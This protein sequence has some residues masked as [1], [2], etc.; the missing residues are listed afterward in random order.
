VVPGNPAWRMTLPQWR[1]DVAAMLRAPDAPGVLRCSMLAD[2]RGVDDGWDL[3]VRLRVL[4]ADM[5]RGTPLMLRYMAREAVRFAPP[6]GVFGALLVERA[7]AGRG[8]G[9]GESGD[10]RRAG[11]RSTGTLDL[12][13]GGLFPLMH[14][15]R[16][17]TLDAGATA[18]DTAGRIAQ[19]QAGG[20]LSAARAADLGEAMDHLL[21]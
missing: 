3:V 6:L 7:T 18:H 14:G 1:A 11:G 10:F 8:D 12:K 15:V 17:L 5:I 16:T 13:R 4:L 9:Q 2:A 19:L 21:G 20:V